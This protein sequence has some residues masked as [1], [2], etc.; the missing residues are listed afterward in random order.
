MCY[1]DSVFWHFFDKL[2]D[3]PQAIFLMNKLHFIVK[4]YMKHNYISKQKK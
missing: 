2:K 3:F 1:L 4:K